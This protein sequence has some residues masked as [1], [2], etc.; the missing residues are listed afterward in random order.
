MIEFKKKCSLCSWETHWWTINIRRVTY[1]WS[2]LITLHWLNK[3]KFNS[4]YK[5]SLPHHQIRQDFKN[6]SQIQKTSTWQIKSL[7]YKY[8]SITWCTSPQFMFIC[9]F[10]SCFHLMLH[11]LVCIQCPC[12]DL[13]TVSDEKIKETIEESNDWRFMPS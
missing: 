9:C 13:V 8:L 1:R 10:S 11:S 4:I 7:P 2:R 3:E 6:K 12:L 5:L